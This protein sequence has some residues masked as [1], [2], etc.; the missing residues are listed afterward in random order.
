[1]KFVKI[2]ALAAAAIGTLF[3]ASCCPSATPQ[4]APPAVAPAK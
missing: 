4:P 2:T 3:A 1:M